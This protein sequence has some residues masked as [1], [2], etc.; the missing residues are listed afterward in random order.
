MVN[1][2]ANSFRIGRRSQQLVDIFGMRRNNNN[3]RNGIM[4]SLVGLGL[5]ALAYGLMR[6]RNGNGNNQI[7]SQITESIQ[8]SFDPVRN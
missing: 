2:I 1:W 4:M 6:G 3:N 8:K 5:G 7:N